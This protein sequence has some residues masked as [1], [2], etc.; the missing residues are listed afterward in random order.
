MLFSS[1]TFLFYFLPVVLAL[2][3]LMPRTWGKNIILFAAGMV[4]YAWGAGLLIA[5]LLL[6]GFITWL[7]GWLIV[8]SRLRKLMAVAGVAVLIAVLFY[9]KYLGFLIDSL[10]YLG[11]S[12]LPRLKIL[13]PA[14]VSFFI[15][16]AVSYI[17]DVYRKN[18]RHEKNPVYVILYISM[19][20]QLLS[21]P[22]VRYH[23]LKDS[24][25]ARS[26]DPDLM[27]SGVRRF[28]IGL[29]KKVLLADPLGLLA[30]QIL[31]S[32]WSMAG[33]SVA[34]IGIIAFTLQLYFDFSGY[35][36][37]AVGTGRM[38]GF[39]L[40]ENFNFPYISRSISEFW[41]RWHMSLSGW[42]NEYL[43]TPLSLSFRRMRKAGVFL[44]LMITFTLCGIW[45]E[46]GWNFLI[47]GAMHGLFLGAEQWFLKSFIQKIKIFGIIYALLIVILS[48]VFVFTDHPAQ[49]MDYFGLMFGMN[50]KGTLG[51]LNFV[52]P[53]HLTLLLLGVFF[54]IPWHETKVFRSERFRKAKEVLS[55]CAIVVLLLLSAMAVTTQTYNPFLYFKF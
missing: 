39:R 40:P 46:P 49:A 43:F 1:V 16:Q 3:Y 41:R 20:P 22:L 26:F 33:P 23:Q 17:V 8:R 6:I 15:F 55:V 35:T 24:L 27:S 31:H 48:F 50:G 9:Y 21:G 51:P 30:D 28:I 42:L 18:A 52:G 38:L 19:F 37:M 14:G 2:Y 25:H 47:W 5:L 11:V 53:H 45:H 36:D 34:W 7:S 54:C 10:I 4:F 44:A 29:S 12:E 32:E 13:L